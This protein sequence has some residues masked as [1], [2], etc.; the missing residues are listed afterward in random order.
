M[1][2]LSTDP[3]DYIRNCTHPTNNPCEVTGHDGVIATCCCDCWNA[4]VKAFRAKRRAEH[5]A[6]LA[7]ENKCDRCG[8]RPWSWYVAGYKLCGY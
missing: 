6:E 1:D 3:E 7:L 4:Y 2:T 5:Q 8:K